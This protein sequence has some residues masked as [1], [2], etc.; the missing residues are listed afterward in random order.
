MSQG[1]SESR[2]YAQ[3]LTMTGNYAAVSTN[4]MAGMAAT[5]SRSIG[6]QHQAADTLTQLAATGRIAG[7]QL[8]AIGIAAEAMQKATGVAVDKTVKDFVSLGDEPVK[9]SLKLNEQYHYLT[10][11]VYDQVYALEEQGKKEQAAAVAQAAFAEQMRTRAEKVVANLGYMERAWNGVTGA[12]KS[13]WDAMLGLGRAATL[14]EVRGKITGVQAQL[15]ELEKQGAASGPAGNV[16]YGMRGRM[17]Q[18]QRLQAELASLRGQ[19][20]TIEERSRQ[21]VAQGEKQRQQD[22]IIAAKARLNEQEKQTRSNAQKRKDEIEQLQRDAALVGMAAEEYQKRAAAIN[23]KYKDP[24]PKSVQ[25]DA[26]TKML[27]KLR[28]QDAA[29]RVALESSTKLTEAEKQQAEFLQQIADLKDKRIL[30][31]DQKSLLAGQEAIKR[32]LALNVEHERALKLKEEIAKVEERSAAVNAQ[33]ASYQKSQAEQYQRQ[34]DAVG[35]GSEAQKR[36]ADVKSIY[37]QYEQ[38]QL[39]LEKA[40]PKSARGSD[41]YVQAQENIRQGLNQSLADHDAYYAALQEK[42]SSWLNGATEAMANYADSSRN[43]MAQ[44]NSAT[45]NAFR[46]MEDGL[47]N[48]V[49]TGKMNF[50]DFAKS[51]I[52]DL[53]RIQARA[54]LSGIFSQLGNLVIGAFSGGAG[55]TPGVSEVGNA[56][57]DTNV[58]PA[59]ELRAD[60][61]PVYAGKPYIVGERGPEF[62]VP[63]ASGSIVPNDA[64]GGMGGLNIAP[65][66]I[67]HINVDSRS[68]QATILQA[69][70]QAKEAAVAAIRDNLMRGG[71]ISRLARR[72]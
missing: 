64:L 1:A 42:Q 31:A 25:D 37:S 21:E 52:A 50:A 11:A 55:G 65:T 51:V 63:P 35:M 27:Q 58:A 68:D 38:M 36:A 62:F 34:L 15:A 70:N 19:E 6:T 71:D 66:I 24:K 30:T 46:R 22:A 49:M 18:M 28:D 47:V 14:D 44:V 26:A 43:V 4:Q 39:Q 7:E 16:G 5:M 29:T 56:T 48:F 59:I 32:Q 54:A 57:I 9:A 61:G 45:S 60:G 2:A 12:A 40:T 41:E 20:K 33:I 17:E 3:A 8:V 10:A 72:S 67:Q 23:E 53:I 69:M 13:A